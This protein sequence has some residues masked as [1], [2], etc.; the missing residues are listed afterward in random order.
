MKRVNTAFRHH[1]SRQPRHF[2]W[3]LSQNQWHWL[4]FMPRHLFYWCERVSGTMVIPSFLSLTAPRAQMSKFC[5]CHFQLSHTW[6][7]ACW[8]SWCRAK[9]SRKVRLRC[10]S[11][12]GGQ[13]VSR[14]ADTQIHPFILPLVHS[15]YIWQA[16]KY[17]FLW[18]ILEN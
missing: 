1:Q 11:E 10:K 16:W 8:W 15:L 12:G 4:T 7:D 14:A 3:H 2:D 5:L 18:F 6:N 9:K 13:S 17:T